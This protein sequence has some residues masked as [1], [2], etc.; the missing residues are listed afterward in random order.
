MRPGQP[1]N[2]TVVRPGAG[3]TDDSAAARAW[4]EQSEGAVRARVR[5][6]FFLTLN[7]APRG[8]ADS[9]VAR[10]LEAGWFELRHLELVASLGGTI[11]MVPRNYL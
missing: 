10:D 2:G 5:P 4:S 8:R 11:E 7:F 9:R 1:R 3:T 6:D